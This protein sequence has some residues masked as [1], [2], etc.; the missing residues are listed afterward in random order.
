VCITQGKRHRLDRNDAGPFGARP[1]R[2]AVL[3]YVRDLMAMPSAGDLVIYGHDSPD[4]NVSYVAEIGAHAG[5]STDELYTFVV[6]RRDI[7]L[8]RPIT[9]PVE[10]YPHFLGYRA[11]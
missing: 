2:A 3:T 1:D 9:H 5:P 11:A 8:P 7:E 4:G 10:L 6:C